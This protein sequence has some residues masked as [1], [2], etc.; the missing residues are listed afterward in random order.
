MAVSSSFQSWEGFWRDAPS[1]RGEVLWDAD[2]EFVAATHLPLF[3]PY[4]DA[5]LPVVDLG[6][7]NGTQTRFLAQRYGRTLGAD[8]SFAAILQARAGDP[9]GSAEY[10]QLDAGDVATLQVLHRELGDSNIYLRGVLHQALPEDRADIAR[11]IATLTGARGRVFDVEP[12]PT[13][14]DVFATLMRRPEGPPA[15]LRAIFDHGITPAEAGDE[16]FERLLCEAGLTVLAAGE[17]PLSTTVLAA[18]GSRIE[19]P[20]RWLVAGQ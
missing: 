1:G 20:S 11:G 18:D 19:L 8:L 5:S 12:A 6:C 16:E 13:A 7:G 15:K 17:L 2:P 3:E 10:R 4:F 9:A 14:K